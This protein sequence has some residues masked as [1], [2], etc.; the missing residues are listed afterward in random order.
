M[1]LN[2]FD[3]YF[4]WGAATSAHQID[5]HN[6]NNDWWQWEQAGKTRSAE[7]SGVAC[8]HKNK[9]KEDLLLAKNLNLNSY[10]FSLE[11][12]RLEPSPGCWD[13]SEWQWLEQLLSE[14]EANRLI[15]FVS[16]HHFTLPAWLSESGGVLATDFNFFYQRFVA[17][18][19]I[20]I[21]ARVTYWCTF[22]EPVVLA[23]G[24]YLGHFMPPG[25]TSWRK[26]IRVLQQ[27][28][29]S[30]SQ[31][32]K[33]IHEYKRVGPWAH[34]PMQVGIAHN[35]LAFEPGR[36]WHPLDQA[37]TK[38]SDYIY[39]WYFLNSLIS[40]S[41]S[42]NSYLDFIGINYYTRGILSWGYEQ[43]PHWP[44][45]PL[46]MSLKFARPGEIMSD[47][48]WS[49]YP[50]GLKDILLK[51]KKFNTPI[52]ITENGWAEKQD[53]VRSR[54]LIEHLQ[55]VAWAIEQGVK[56]HGYFHWA[57]LDNFEWGEGFMPRFGLYKVDY[58]SLERSK[59]AAAE[60]YSR[61]AF[62]HACQN[63]PDAAVLKAFLENLTK[64]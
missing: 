31:A 22:N 28:I 46:P 50:Q 41:S 33:Q 32:Y 27:L 64:R 48:G 38:V 16:I 39:N 12:S 10:R 54:F 5:G 6:T 8:D 24:G 21:G 25:E 52:I 1:K 23:V 51:L 47:L 42:Q 60:L 61:V 43:S 11:W 37:L 35:M 2:P 44:Q 45:P 57:L 19:L 17:Q 4:L 20:R 56:I 36:F 26:F 29:I 9:F 15:P 40:K 62:S 58:S 59:T 55:A 3:T 18:V 34:L 13:E 7:S 63:P 30:H 49:F 53:L 14:C